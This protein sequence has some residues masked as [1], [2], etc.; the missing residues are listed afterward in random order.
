MGLKDKA[1]DHKNLVDF[2]NSWGRNFKSHLP[3]QAHQQQ[4]A[5]AFARCEFK[6]KTLT[7]L[8]Q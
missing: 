4:C 5:G 8:Y 2:P 6:K 1:L 7:P 3:S